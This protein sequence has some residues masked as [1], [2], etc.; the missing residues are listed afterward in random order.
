MAS[1]LWHPLL[2]AFSL[3]LPLWLP[4]FGA[5][6]LLG[7]RSHSCIS[8]TFPPLEKIPSLRG[9]LV[10]AVKIMDFS[11]LLCDA[12]HQLKPWC[13]SFESGGTLKAES[14]VSWP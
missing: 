9:I 7:S 13:K 1:A 2:G 5:L 14:F 4:G 11:T 12:K 6:G 10:P 8:K 3:V